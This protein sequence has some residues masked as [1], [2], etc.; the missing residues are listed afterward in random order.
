MSKKMKNTVR[1][2]TNNPTHLE[3]PSLSRALDTYGNLNCLI[4]SGLKEIIRWCAKSTKND[5]KERYVFSLK[6]LNYVLEHLSTEV[7]VTIKVLHLRMIMEVSGVGC[8]QK[9]KRSAFASNYV[10]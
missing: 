8:L 2:L 1:S 4:D 3:A 10:A 5:T 9:V 7:L 6:N